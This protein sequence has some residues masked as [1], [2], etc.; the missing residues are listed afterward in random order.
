VLALLV[1]IALTAPRS[2]PHQLSSYVHPSILGDDEDVLDSRPHVKA[3]KEQLFAHT[4][5]RGEEDGEAIQIITLLSTEF[6]RSGPKDKKTIIAEITRAMRVTRRTARDGT[7]SRQLV[8]KGAEVLGRFG[9]DS[10]DALIRLATDRNHKDDNEVRV[11]ILTAL[12]KTKDK[13]AVKVLTKEL[14]ESQARVQAGA[15][16]ALGEFAHLKYK[17]RKAIFEDLLKL[18][19]SAQA[20]HQSDPN[21]TASADRW[22]RVPSPCQ[23]SMAKL[24]GTNEGSAN[25]WQRWWN[26][27]KNRNWDKR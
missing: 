22:R 8:L 17:E 4:K 7:R 16:E 9:P 13:K 5:K 2:A 18:L 21:G 14:D 6:K 27:N 11:A 20:D 26:K 1:L 12:G 24:S 15:A 3:L 23:R 10:V 19:M 25:N